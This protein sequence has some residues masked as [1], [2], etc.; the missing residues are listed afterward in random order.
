MQVYGIIV[1]RHKPRGEVFMALSG[2]IFLMGLV[3]FTICVPLAAKKAE[4]LSRHQ[5]TQTLSKV[6]A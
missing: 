5:Q 4:A 3:L 6:R 2:R 1:P